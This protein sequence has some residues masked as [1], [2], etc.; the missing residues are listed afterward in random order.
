MRSFFIGDGL[1]E[2]YA[3]RTVVQAI[4]PILGDLEP[5]SRIDGLWAVQDQPQ[6]GLHIAFDP[7]A[8]AGKQISSVQFGYDSNGAPSWRVFAPDSSEN[9]EPGMLQVLNY[10]GGN[11]DGTRAAIGFDR[12]DVDII[13][14]SCVEMSLV[15]GANAAAR[16][17]GMFPASPRESLRLHKLFP[18]GCTDLASRLEEQAE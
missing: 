12:G 17:G 5:D 11:P 15:P 1:N 16:S 9:A 4:E 13:V 6:T 2:P 3:I 10:R 18:S 7:D 14:H 8:N